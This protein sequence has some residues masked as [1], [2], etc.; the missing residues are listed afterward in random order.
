MLCSSNTERFAVAQTAVSSCSLKCLLGCTI[1]GE[2]LVDGFVSWLVVWLVGWL[3]GF[4]HK[5]EVGA[6]VGLGERR[7]TGNQYLCTVNIRIRKSSGR[8]WGDEMC[9]GD[10][11]VWRGGGGGWE[12]RCVGVGGGV[13]TQPLLCNHH[14]HCL[15]VINC[16]RGGEVVSTPDSVRLW[17]GFASTEH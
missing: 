7:G 15:W 9:K 5:D 12:E 6:G 8:L 4:D 3:V 14:W 1:T 13:Q 10:L 16:G 17:A 11:E 2:W